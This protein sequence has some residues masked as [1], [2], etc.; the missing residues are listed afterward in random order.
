MPDN[1]LR[2]KGS[3]NGIIIQFE[4][5]DLGQA[6]QLLE[7]KLK[8]NPSFFVGSQAVLVIPEESVLDAQILVKI[9]EVLCAASISLSEIRREGSASVVE[10]IQPPAPQKSPSKEDNQKLYWLE[11]RLRSG[12]KLSVDGDLVLIGDVN[13]GAE[14]S[15]IGNILVWG[16]LQG[17]AHAGQSGNENARIMALRLKATQL[18]IAG[19]ISRSPDDSLDPHDPEVARVGSNGIVIETWEKVG[20]E[21]PLPFWRRLL[22][23][24][25]D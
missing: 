3:K 12:E 23:G 9:H 14:I 13:P 1:Q 11:R 18:R 5:G 10:V 16:C 2:I 7:D 24:R 17:V 25:E 15:A 8:E 4:E 19:F 22:H 6:I 21:D 20:K